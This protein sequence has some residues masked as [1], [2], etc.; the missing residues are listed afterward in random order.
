[1]PL[2][3]PVPPE[4][5]LVFFTQDLFPFPGGIIHFRESSRVYPGKVLGQCALRGTGSPYQEHEE[6]QE[7]KEWKG[8][9]P[10]I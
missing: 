1:M 2:P 10:N 8:T 9:K 6:D 7:M 3:C 4:L 5:V